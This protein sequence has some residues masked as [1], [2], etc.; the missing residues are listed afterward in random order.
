MGLEAD[1]DLGWAWRS[2]T[3]VRP[4]VDCSTLHGLGQETSMPPSLGSSAKWEAYSSHVG[5]PETDPVF[6]DMINGLVFI[7]A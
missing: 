6:Q 5:S 4:P 2:E 7:N 1:N 3:R